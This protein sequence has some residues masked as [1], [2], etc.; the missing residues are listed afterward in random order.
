MKALKRVRKW[1]V[2]AVLAMQAGHALAAAHLTLQEVVQKV[3]LGNPEVLSKWHT[4]KS[5]VGRCRCRAGGLFAQDR[6][7][8]RHRP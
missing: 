5:A 4:F 8:L 7:H 6:L 2:M 3:V 1:L